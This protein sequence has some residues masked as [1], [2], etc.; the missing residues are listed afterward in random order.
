MFR[1]MS[2][3]QAIIPSTKIVL[4]ILIFVVAQIKHEVAVNCKASRNNVFLLQ[5]R[6]ETWA[7]SCYLV[8][9]DSIAFQKKKHR[10]SVSSPSSSPSLSPPSHSLEAFTLPP[11]SL[12]NVQH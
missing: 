11:L 12:D 10:S 2:Y 5:Y 7:Q 9:H 8:D 3:C 4:V 1:V 6:K